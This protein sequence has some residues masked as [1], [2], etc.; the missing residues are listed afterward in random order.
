MGAGN[1]ANQSINAWTG[2]IK[3]SSPTDIPFRLGKSKYDLATYSGR[4]RHFF[5]VID[6]RTLFTSD[7]DLGN[8]QALLTAYKSGWLPANITNDDMWKAQK[9]VQAIIHPDTGEK[10]PMPFRMAGY[11]PFGAF[12]K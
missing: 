12:G 7:I 9:T 2:P 11:V 6:P 3:P 1:V 5:N 10:I 4:V 8:S